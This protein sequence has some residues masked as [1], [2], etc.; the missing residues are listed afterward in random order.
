MYVDCTDRTGEPFIVREATADDA[1]VFLDHMREASAEPNR[2][3]GYPDERCKDEQSQRERLQEIVDDPGH[4]IGLAMMDDVLLGVVEIECALARRRRAHVGSIGLSVSVG[5]RRRGI[6]QILVEIAIQRA[7]KS[8][9]RKIKL[10]VF[11]QNNA[12]IQLYQKLSFRNVGR[13]RDEVMRNDGTYDDIIIM[14]RFL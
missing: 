2:L 14:E 11:A 4:W 6:G 13:L 10:E 9:L 3:L 5:C 12:A 8:G 7:Q 1:L